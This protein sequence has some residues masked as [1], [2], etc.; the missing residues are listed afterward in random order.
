V[1]VDAAIDNSGL[2]Y[3]A[4]HP[5]PDLHEVAR[6]FSVLSGLVRHHPS[7]PH[8]ACFR[9]MP[10]RP[11]LEIPPPSQEAQSSTRSTSCHAEERSSGAREQ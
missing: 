10:E 1:V 4:R 8:T 6:A 9:A 2:D 5:T 3:Q 11:M 7:I